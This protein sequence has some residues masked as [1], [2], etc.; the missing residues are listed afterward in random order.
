MQLKEYDNLL[1]QHD[2]YYNYSDDYTVWSKGDSSYQRLLDISKLTDDHAKLF[3]AWGKLHFCGD[4]F[5][6]PVF[7]RDD[8]NRVRDEV[9]GTKDAKPTI[10]F[11]GLPEFTCRADAS[12]EPVVLAHVWINRVMTT[13][14]MV[15]SETNDKRFETLSAIYQVEEA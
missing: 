12:G 3:Q 6:I 15:L 5:Q 11:Q 13:T 10:L 4:A 9:L 14:D 2:W 8:L 7:S 1:A